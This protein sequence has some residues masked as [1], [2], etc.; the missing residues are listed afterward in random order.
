MIGTTENPGKQVAP[1]RTRS[2]A[3]KSEILLARGRFEMAGAVS[4]R[5]VLV[6]T[7]QPDLRQLLFQNDAVRP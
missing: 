7:R 5:S 1:P 3:L 6:R 4:I 2:R